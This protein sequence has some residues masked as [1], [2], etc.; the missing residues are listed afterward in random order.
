MLGIDY[1]PIC[2]LQCTCYRCSGR[3]TTLVP[4]FAAECE[5]QG[6]GPEE[7]DFNFVF[8]CSR[9]LAKVAKRNGDKK[10]TVLS[11]STR[12][13]T[14]ASQVETVASTGEIY[15]VSKVPKE[16]FPAELSSGINKDPSRKDDYNTIFTPEGTTLCAESAKKSA[17]DEAKRILAAAV[18]CV[19]GNVDFCHVCKEPGDLVCCDKCPR[20]F[21]GH[22]LTMDS[23]VV[24][25][26]WECPRCLD[27]STAN[28]SDTMK[29]EAHLKKLL[30]IFQQYSATHDNF[31]SKVELI[32][33]IY[34]MIK[35]LM[36]YDFG[37]TFSEP[38]DMKLVR[39]YKTYVKRPMDLGTISERMMNGDYCTTIKQR[40]DLIGADN[41]TDMDIIILKLLR[42]I[43]QIW[44]NCFLYNREGEI[45]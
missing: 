23:K 45:G 7:C 24:S 26:R 40:K 2:T 1:C 44:H 38:V 15:V 12:R 19:D 3:V 37:D 43:E 5:E 9:A 8:H 35:V 27:D 32:S 6:V 21:H 20:G 10:A 31:S 29:G 17:K 42:D 14:Q 11:T 33:K 4:Q 16:D 30:N 28:E 39:D 22:C 41:T 34:D 18:V 13:K 36:E 25:G